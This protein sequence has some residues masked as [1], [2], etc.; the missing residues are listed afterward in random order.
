[1]PPR[2]AAAGILRTL[3]ACA[4][5]ALAAA[6]PALA[7]TGAGYVEIRALDFEGNESFSEL[8]LRTAIVASATHCRS[9]ALLPLCWLGTSLDRQFFDPRV[10]ALDSVRVRLF[11]FERGFREARVAL[12]SVREDDALRVRF[13]I[14]E[15]RPVVVDSLRIEGAEGMPGSLVRRLPLA[16]GRPLN[17][18]AMQAARDTLVARLQDRGFYHA[19]A[20]LNYTID[21]AR[22]YSATVEYLLLPGP[23]TRFGEIEVLGASRVDTALVRRRLAFRPG[24]PFSRTALL[25][26]Q[27]DLFALEVFRHIEITT[28]G[29]VGDTILPVRVQVNEGHLNRFRVGLGVSTAEYFNAEGRWT[30]RNFLGGGRRLE[31]R[32]RVAN[33]VSRPLGDLPGFEQCRDIYCDLSGSLTLDFAQPRFL[34]DALTLGSGVFLE[35]V[36]VP[37]VYV[38]T[39]RGAGVSL[40]RSLGQASAGAVGY[41]PE[42]TRLESAEE[43]FCVSFTACEPEEIRVLRETH[44]LAPATLAFSRERAN[45]LVAPTRGHALRL[46]AEVAGD[47]TGSEFAYLRGVGEWVTYRE[48]FRGVVFATRLR[49]G[50]ARALGAPGENLGLH[51]Q[52]R[53]FAGGPNS[54]R[55]FAQFRL[56]PKVLTVDAARV[57]AAPAGEG[58][59]GCTP[60][61]INVGEC[62]VGLLAERDP[63]ELEVRP[64]GGNML[65]EG[66]LELRF[67][68]VLQSFR[69]AL[70]L[71][72]GQVWRQ[73][74]D[75][76]LQQLAWSPGVGVRYFSP[77]GPIRV[78]V[79]YNALGPERLAVLSTDVCDGRVDPCGPIEPGAGYDWRQLA[80]GSRLRAQRPVTWNPFDTFTDRLQI[81]FS[82][83]QAF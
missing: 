62:S 68:L 41:R 1:M 33:L 42:L 9:S 47:V 57:L 24:D 22:P 70:F 71:D 5:L 66:N 79:G 77:I 64:I 81:H 75:I 73:A 65:L 37:Q 53:F 52:K 78:D 11:Y 61:A 76:D 19:D 13:R 43:V 2:N 55:G 34:G 32:A 58:G 60:Q 56:G 83:G 15:G 72:F 8:E 80:N 40:S 4:C 12:D 6:A 14:E 48:P 45:N 69:G 82:I 26:S 20:L 30:G 23:L 51:P 16:V 3:L 44:W 25:Q 27:R 54:V 39:S 10:L 74:D 67:P 49:P 50:W 18:L 17:E 38:R 28:R 36:T 35:R 29:G 46:E 7:Q 31:A 63:E 21:R 59:A